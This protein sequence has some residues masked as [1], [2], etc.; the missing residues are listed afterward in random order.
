MLANLR[1]QATPQEVTLDGGESTTVSFTYE[2]AADKEPGNYSYV[3]S[4]LQ[5]IASH[6]LT[7]TAAN[8]SGQAS[9]SSAPTLDNR[10]DGLEQQRSVRGVAVIAG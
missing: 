2:V 8:G 4:S 5:E 7:I 6:S 1:P 3:A 10:A 9:A